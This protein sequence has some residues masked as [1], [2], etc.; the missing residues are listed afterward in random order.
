MKKDKGWVPFGTDSGAGGLEP[1]VS[2]ASMFVRPAERA[3]MPPV[4]RSIPASR[5]RQA[6]GPV[7]SKEFRLA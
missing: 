5:L 6:L 3:S 2:V 7:P 1:G 4:V